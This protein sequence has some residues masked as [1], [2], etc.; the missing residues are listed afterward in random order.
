VFHWETWRDHE[1]ASGSWPKDR[2]V[3]EFRKEWITALTEGSAHRSRAE[4][5]ELLRR[6]LAS[7]RPEPKGSDGMLFHAHPQFGGGVQRDYH[8]RRIEGVWYIVRIDSSE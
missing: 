5:D 4:T 2:P 8:L 7:G 6:M 3:A 1:V